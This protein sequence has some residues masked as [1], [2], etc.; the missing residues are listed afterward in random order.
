VV[1][2]DLDAVCAVHASVLWCGGFGAQRHPARR[3]CS[4]VRGALGNL[5]DGQAGCGGDNL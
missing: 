3:G 4:A 5:R 2:R 1:A